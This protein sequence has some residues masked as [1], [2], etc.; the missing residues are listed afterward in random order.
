MKYTKLQTVVTKVIEEE[1]TDIAIIKSIFS[2]IKTDELTCAIRLSSGPKM[3]NIRIE[4]VDETGFTILMVNKQSSLRKK[5]SY[6]E[7]ADLEVNIDTDLIC[8]NKS[9]VSRWTI[10]DQSGD[11]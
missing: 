6:D 8:K 1:I 10:L 5:V 2:T 4:Q 7:V 9:N 3:C 11:V